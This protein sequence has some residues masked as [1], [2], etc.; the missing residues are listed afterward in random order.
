MDPCICPAV[1]LSEP[2]VRHIPDGMQY[3]Y[4]PH[5]YTDRSTLIDLD[6]A[7]RIM[8]KIELPGDIQFMPVDPDTM[9][10]K[11]GTRYGFTAFSIALGSS[12]FQRCV[13]T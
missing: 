5:S 3:V 13:A 1:K 11:L 6:L 10:Y 8:S 2:G 4:V 12:Y 7:N 9:L